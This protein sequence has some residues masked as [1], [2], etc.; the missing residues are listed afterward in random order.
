MVVLIGGTKRMGLDDLE[1]KL[2]PLPAVYLSPAP[3]SI[4]HLFVAS[5]DGSKTKY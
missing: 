4:V 2:L 3:C 5:F 1:P